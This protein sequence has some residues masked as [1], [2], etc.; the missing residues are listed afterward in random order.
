M[1]TAIVPKKDITL[2]EAKKIIVTFLGA[3]VEKIKLSETNE[4]VFWPS[5]DHP[6]KPTYDGCNINNYL[7]DTDWNW[8][9]PLLEYIESLGVYTSIT[10][11][12]G[13]KYYSVIIDIPEHHTFIAERESESK[14][15]AVF[16][17]IVQFIITYS[18]LKNN[19]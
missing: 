1:A 15:D 13:S 5:S 3:T 16:W 14:I 6:N 17:A 10:K 8:L 7:Y 12:I 4:H 11:R 18:K 2:I 9:M 19:G